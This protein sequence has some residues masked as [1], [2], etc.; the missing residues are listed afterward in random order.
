[1]FEKGDKGEKGIFFLSLFTFIKKVQTILL[2]TIFYK[3]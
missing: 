1:M 3:K 2:I